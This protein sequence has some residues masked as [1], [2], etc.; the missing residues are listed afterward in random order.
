[1]RVIRIEFKLRDKVIQ[2]E[3]AASAGQ[4]KSLS[5]IKG[6]S[7]LGAVAGRI[8]TRLGSSDSFTAF[9]SGKVRFC[10]ALP[11]SPSGLETLPVPLAWMHEKGESATKEKLLLVDKISSTTLFNTMKDSEGLVQMRQGYFSKAGELVQPITTYR[12]RTAID[13]SRFGRAQESQLFGYEALSAGSRWIMRIHLDD[14]AAKILENSIMDALQDTILRF[15]S[16]RGAEY[17]RAE[18]LSLIAEDAAEYALPDA[19]IK[20]VVVY[21]VSDTAM[22]DP[23]TGLPTLTPRAHYFGLPEKWKLVLHRSAVLTRR[24]SPY[25]GHRRRRDLERTV[26]RQGSVLFFKGDEEI[27]IESLSTVAKEHAGAYRQDGLGQVLFNPWFLKEDFNNHFVKVSN[28]LDENNPVL[29]PKTMLGQL[30][31]NKTRDRENSVEVW[32][33][34]AQIEEE[35]SRILFRLRSDKKVLPG[36]SQWQQAAAIAEQEFRKDKSDWDRFRRSFNQMTSSGV[37]SHDWNNAGDA[38]VELLKGANKFEKNTKER[39]KTVAL[40]ARLVARGVAS[41]RKEAKK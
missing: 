24:Y 7:L 3:Y 16:S 32:K 18:I 38:S 19:A 17:G 35:I 29:F 20:Q 41:K 8:Y 13:A 6:A 36:R 2:S 14:D 33:L 40:A 21:L 9:H 22:M 10:N 39:L 25:N 4:H 34:A 37:A 11:I 27:D 12:L 31:E 1:M 28:A 30:M 23:E 5:Y 15:G 26:L